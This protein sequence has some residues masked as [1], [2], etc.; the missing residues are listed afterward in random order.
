MPLVQHLL[1]ARA[2]KRA[3]ARPGT[4]QPPA[5][6]S[7]ASAAGGAAP[8]EPPP[9][10]AAGSA[11][12]SDAS[13]EAGDDGLAARGGQAAYQALLG[14]LLQRDR[15]DFDAGTEASSSGD[16][17]PPAAAKG[18]RRSGGAHAGPPA[19][20]PAPAELGCREGARQA[21]GGADEPADRGGRAAAEPGPGPAPAEAEAGAAGDAPALA[22]WAQRLDEHFGRCA[23][24]RTLALRLEQGS[25]VGSLAPGASSPPAAAHAR[26]AGQ[27][28]ALPRR[29]A[30]AARARPDGLL[31]QVEAY[32]AWQPTRAGWKCKGASSGAATQGYDRGGRGGRG[33][34]PADRARGGRGGPQRLAARDLARQRRPAAPGAGACPV[35]T[36]T[37][38][39]LW[40]DG[41]VAGAIGP[42][43]RH[44]SSGRRARAGRMAA[45][46]R[47]RGG[48]GGVLQSAER[49][50][51]CAQAPATL[52]GCG[53][54]ERLVRRWREVHAADGAA[55]A[56]AGRRRAAGRPGG[57]AAPGGGAQP[58]GGAAGAFDTPEQRALFG[59]LASY[60]DVL[61][62]C[63]PYLTRC[64]APRAA[65]QPHCVD[66]ARE[67]A[68]G[69]R[70]SAAP[71]CQ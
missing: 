66:A 61:F 17:A 31:H 64:A 2:R 58:G 45:A 57:G 13:D 25:L 71:A 69:S 15:A 35:G 8:A 12:D 29:A 37:R 18:R 22:A 34:R 54:P 14:G 59:V 5:K 46:R 42:C 60:K 52:A 6:R 41:A 62:P 43:Q 20:P 23:A 68:S 28:G 48:G 70:P 10:A 40:R 38:R 16:E 11:S 39:P 44:R 7:R 56:K 30:R 26:S 55:A 33:T 9:G 4:Q 49:R 1:A 65:P 47:R 24:G 67:R 19:A 36:G 3:S 51:R 63:R 53:V 21:A 50:R 27:G 32:H